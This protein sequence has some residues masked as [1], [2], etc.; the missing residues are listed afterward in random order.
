MLAADVA[1]VNS[2]ASPGAVYVAVSVA[3]APRALPA[4][5]SRAVG[6]PTVYSVALVASVTVSTTVSTSPDLRAGEE[7]VRSPAPL[8][9]V[10]TVQPAVG[11]V[12]ASL[13]VTSTVVR[14]TNSALWA[15]GAVVS[16]VAPEPGRI[17]ASP[18]VASPAMGPPTRASMS[19]SSGPS[20]SVDATVNWYV[21][22]LVAVSETAVIAV[23]APSASLF[24]VIIGVP[25]T[26][27]LNVTATVMRSPALASLFAVRGMNGDGPS[28][29][30]AVITS[31]G[32]VAT[33]PGTLASYALP[34]RSASAAGTV[35]E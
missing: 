3:G 1:A 29:I 18:M 8:G 17:E 9:V 35:T 15:I 27:S 19:K 23:C 25:M 7:T 10:W 33:G 28:S 31:T 34:A 11:T 12:M 6:I 21:H 13:N 14:S 5:S 16:I 24:T 22:P 30:D 4:R 20:V 2:G 32:H 26:S